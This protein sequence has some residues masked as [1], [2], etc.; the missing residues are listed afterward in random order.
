MQVVSD[1]GNMT[2]QTVLALEE[3][4]A[5]SGARPGDRFAAEAELEKKLGVSRVVVREAVSRLRAL[6][7]LQSR[8]GLGLIVSKPNPVALFGQ[9]ITGYAT[10]AMDMVH[11]GELRYSLEIGAVELVAARAT[12]EQLVRLSELAEEFA[13]CGRPAPSSRVA[14]DVEMDFHKTILESA[15][16]PILADMHHVLAVFFL[17][18]PREVERH[19]VDEANE[20]TIWQHREI[21]A[22]L[23]ARHVERARAL[24]GSHLAHLI[25]K[26]PNVAQEQ[27]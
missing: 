12:S 20:R 14:D 10:N 16:N 11:L 6:G 25:S 27:E 7:I 21:A 9:V 13:A 24:L 22:A 18:S 5:A 3:M 23:R 8:R 1:N 26:R 4:L 2:E 15:H 19:F 17:R